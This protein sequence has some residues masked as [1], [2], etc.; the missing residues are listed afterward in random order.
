MI[1]IVAVRLIGS[2]YRNAVLKHEDTK[3][4]KVFTKTITFE[5][6]RYVRHRR[7][8]PWWHCRSNHVTTKSDVL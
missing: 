2:G 8:T 6:W 5:T 3:P 7:L 1:G 4:T